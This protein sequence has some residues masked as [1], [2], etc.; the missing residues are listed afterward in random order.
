MINR[1]KKN[2]VH[3]KNTTQPM[4]CEGLKCA[5][6]NNPSAA[7]S[8]PVAPGRDGG[9]PGGGGGKGLPQPEHSS[10]RVVTFQNQTIHS[11]ALG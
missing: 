2:R 6:E 11:L 5:L 1:T 8:P 4:F 10:H 9:G 3:K 7:F